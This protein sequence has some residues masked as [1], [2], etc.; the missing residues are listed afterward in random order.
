MSSVPPLPSEPVPPFGH[1]SAVAARAASAL[2]ALLAEPLAPGL[3]I[4]ATPIGHLADITL[5]AL[6]VLASADLVLCED[7]RHSAKLMARYA[8]T[9]RLEP[10]HE[11]N[12]AQVRPRI[13]A[14][15]AGGQRIAL[16]SDAGTPLVSD[17]GY[18][19]VLAAIEAGHPVIAIPGASATLAALAVAGLP[20]DAFFFA[21]FLPPKSGQRRARL[22][23]LAAVP[24][25]LVLFEAPGRVVDCLTD[26][27]AVLGDRPVAMARELTKLHETVRRGTA[28][29][30][31]DALARDAVRGECVLLVG[32]P[33]VIMIDDAAICAALKPALATQPVSQA[34][35]EVSAALGV[36][37]SRVYALALDLSQ[38]ED[39][40]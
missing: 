34:A 36:P 39:R 40:S 4:V 27:A 11:H 22:A 31:A 18:K 23:D 19:L 28:A 6:A 2:A 10:Y 29:A 13:L 33:E 16:I 5:R 7:T 9:P 21:G 26:I 15:L 20:T 35:R 8:L 14:A 38:T 24:G 1:G 32:P 25:T 3:Y 17:P 12:A 30:L 37:R